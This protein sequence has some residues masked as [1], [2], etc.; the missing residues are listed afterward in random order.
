VYATVAELLRAYPSCRQILIDIPIGLLEQ[1]AEG[2]RC[3]KEVRRLLG[4]PR[5][6]SVFPPPLRPALQCRTRAEASAVN[7]ARSG[8]GIGAQ[9]WNICNKIR[10]VDEHL[11]GVPSATERVR[12]AHPE[13]LFWA[14]NNREPMRHPK[15][16][17]AGMDERLAVLSRFLSSA[18]EAVKH[19]AAAFPR[20]AVKPDDLVDALALALAA[21]AG[22]KALSSVP[23]Q[24]QR[25][26]YGLP[27][28]IVY[29]EPSCVQ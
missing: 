6:S 7:Y 22:E 3:D 21:S 9:T 27:M 16:T 14:L 20:S 23:T 10:E 24:A 11:R 8:K 28:E 5:A 18:E 25:D 4:R 1:G 2:R 29:W 12:E 17:A 26:A 13:L 19:A 15:S